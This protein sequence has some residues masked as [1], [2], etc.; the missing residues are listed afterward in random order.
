MATRQAASPVAEGQVDLWH[1]CLARNYNRT[2]GN[3][4]RP[5]QARQ[6]LGRAR[7]EFTRASE[8]FAGATVTLEDA[9]KPYGEPRFI[10]AGVLDGRLVVVGLDAARQGAP[11]YQHEKSQ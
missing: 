7:F 5:H 4:V 6:N 1:A 11:H 2:H 9:R 10:T 8:V 3:H